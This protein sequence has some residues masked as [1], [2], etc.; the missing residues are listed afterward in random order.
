LNP[1]GEGWTFTEYYNQP[2][3]PLGSPG[4]CQNIG[5]D[6]YLQQN[7][8]VQATA[9]LLPIGSSTLVPAS[10]ANSHFKKLTN[11]ASG[12][13]QCLSTQQDGSYPSYDFEYV[14]SSGTDVPAPKWR[15]ITHPF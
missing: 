14:N 2:N 9:F 7:E 15:V 8:P 6:T 11:D 10:G 13:P 1:G 3:Q 5:Y 4:Y 12:I